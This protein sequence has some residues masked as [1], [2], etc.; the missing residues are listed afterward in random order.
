MTNEAKRRVVVTGMGIIC[1]I[2]TS[3]SEFW[4]NCLNGFTRV[5][6]IPGHWRNYS[7]FTST[8]LSPL[9]AI[10]F[11]AY[12]I[13]LIDSNRLDLSTQMAI[14]SASMALENAGID[15]E[16][17]NV[18]HAAYILKGI[19]PART[20]VIYGTGAGGVNTLLAGHA[21]QALSNHKKA[22][23][24]MIKSIDAEKNRL[25][26]ECLAGI[27]NKMPLPNRAN[28]FIVSMI[29]PSACSGNI[30]IKYGL[31]GPSN[32]LCSACA[33]GTVA[34]GH[35]YRAIKSGMID[36]A[37]TGGA[38]YLHDDYGSIFRGFDMIGALAPDNGDKD[39][40]CRPF[41]KQHA[42]FLFSEGASATLILEELDH[43]RNRGAEVLGEIVGF[44]ETCDA[45]N[46][47]AI[48]KNGAQIKRMIMAALDESG[49]HPQAIDYIN[50]HGTGTVVND[51]AE[52]QIIND[53][54]GK[55]PLVNS[56]KSILGHTI[57]ASGAIEAIVS[58]LSIKNSKTHICRNLEEPILDLNFVTEVKEREINTAI[59]QSFAFGGQ[60]SVLV[61][62]GFQY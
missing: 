3:I 62:R 11:R 50:T 17:R 38:E 35:A 15:K 26:A 25:L 34:I 21:F 48:E 40:S 10:D 54:F 32:T 5:E 7:A 31:T 43:A 55:R 61:M 23:T 39:K 47:L 45:S 42:G 52:A 51:E 16:I 56:T 44:A 18:R 2:G 60:N 36:V 37:V 4:E 28:P 20:G 1:S 46:I 12:D 27:A 58:I 33:S 53:I 9:P 30:S 59:S 24:A 22:L 6:N 41:D 13:S 14:A 8:I 57:G 19:D 29:M 49:L